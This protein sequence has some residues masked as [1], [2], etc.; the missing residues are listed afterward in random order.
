MP[1]PL[2]LPLGLPRWLRLLGHLINGQAERRGKSTI[3]HALYPA[4]VGGGVGE[5]GYDE[6]RKLDRLD[7]CILKVKAE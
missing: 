6:Q 1:L 5:V 7:F 3:A 2:P 4:Y